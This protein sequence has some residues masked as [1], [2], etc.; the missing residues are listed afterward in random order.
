MWEPSRSLEETVLATSS[1]ELLY[2]SESYELVPALIEVR[3]LIGSF[4]FMARPFVANWLAM[5]PS[6]KLLGLDRSAADTEITK[7]RRDQCVLGCALLD[8]M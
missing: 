1:L 7:R 2:M 4:F 3:F 8:V 5:E 6:S